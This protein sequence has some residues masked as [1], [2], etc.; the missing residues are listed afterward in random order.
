MAIK[1]IGSPTGELDVKRFHANGVIMESSCPECG[2]LITRDLSHDHLYYPKI[3]EPIS[4]YS[5]CDDCELEWADTIQL[6]ISITAI[7]GK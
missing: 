6:N 5:W 3:N 4:I 2:H 1:I 7:E